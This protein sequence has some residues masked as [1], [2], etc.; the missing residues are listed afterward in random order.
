MREQDFDVKAY[1]CLHPTGKFGLFQKREIPIP[2]QMYFVQRLLNKDQRFAKS[3]TY[4]F[5]AHQYVERNMLEKQINVSGFRGSLNSNSEITNL[6][7]CFSVF[8]K[9]KGSPKYWQLARS[10]LIAKV[11]Q[12]G[13]FHVFFTLSCAEMRW[14]EVYVCILKNMGISGLEIRH[15]RDGNW[16]GSDAEVFVIDDTLEEPLPLMEYLKNKKMCKN[17]TLMNYIMLITRIFDDRVKSFIKNIVMNSSGNEPSFSYYNYRIEFQARGLPHVHGV[18]WLDFNWLKHWLYQQWDKMEDKKKEDHDW[19]RKKEE[20]FEKSKI[21]FDL[22]EKNDRDMVVKLVDLMISCKIPKKEKDE[23]LNDYVPK[24]QKHRHSGTCWKKGKLNCR[25]GFPKLP[26]E[27]TLI[28]IPI[29]ERFPKWSK[30]KKEEKLK[31]YTEILEKAKLVL[32]DK[33]LD[34]NMSYEKFYEAVGAT[35]KEYD[36]AIST[37]KKGKVIV[38]ERT[39]GDIWINNYNPLW[40]KCWNANLDIQYAIDEYAII[41]YVVSYVGKDESGMTQFLK[42]VLHKTKGMERKEQLRALKMAW[43]THRQIGAS[44]TVYR[45]LPGLHLKDSNIACIFV[46]SGFPENRA[47]LFIKVIEGEKDKE[48]GDEFEDESDDEG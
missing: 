29:D 4:L 10:E 14:I 31:R 38:L 22:D 20:D 17:A 15:G 5:M 37:T 18:L 48:Y 42:D 16:D 23:T 21:Q 26:S 13:P 46:S 40:L 35:K 11:Q 1:P 36:N 25:F 12:L 7:D 9:I 45:I 43:L 34:V 30:E 3:I 32:S 24:L 44:E 39:V 19:W 6:D 8:Q 33:K 2:D 28:A 47:A 27:K 41:T